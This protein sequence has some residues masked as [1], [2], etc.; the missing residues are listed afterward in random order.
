MCIFKEIF[1]LPSF[2]LLAK[3]Q[4]VIL[5]S[6]T[7]TAKMQVAFIATI[8]FQTSRQLITS[9]F[10]FFSKIPE[11]QDY[12]IV[13]SLPVKLSTFFNCPNKLQIRRSLW[14]NFFI[15]LIIASNRCSLEIWSLTRVEH[16]CKKLS[17]LHYFVNTS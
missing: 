10:N 8:S 16:T 15:L 3:L 14:T 9:L 5:Y 13:P 1:F 4:K 6:K 2:F 12:W 7:E 17:Y 11:F